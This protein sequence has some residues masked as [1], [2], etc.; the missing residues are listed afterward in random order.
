MWGWVMT[1][2]PFEYWQPGSEERQLRMFV[3]HRFGNDEALYDEVRNA[4]E[5]NGFSV[6]DMSLNSETPLAGPRGGDLPKLQLQA[7]IAARIYTSDIVIAPSRPAISRSQWV[8]WEVQ[9]AA[10]G[11][12]IPILF[13]NE[14]RLQRRTRL[15]AQVDELDLAHAVCDPEPNEIVRSITTL[16]QGRPHW[17][18]RQEEPDET[19]RFRGPPAFARNEVLRVYPFRSR[20]PPALSQPSKR[21]FWGFLAGGNQHG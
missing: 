15:V 6:Q 8:T 18:V 7:E 1:A 9:L 19:I 5:R 3:S 4:L 13:V 12:G 11:Y 17:G 16:L 10:I 20:L 21:R 14:R 2:T